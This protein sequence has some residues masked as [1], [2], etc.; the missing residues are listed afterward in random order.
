MAG[1]NGNL[2]STLEIMDVR[3]CL[4][5]DSLD[6]GTLCTSEKVNP[7]SRYR[8]GYWYRGSDGVLAFQRPRGK[9]Y[10][11]PRTPVD[12][13]TGLTKEYYCLHHFFGYN[14]SARP[15]GT[16]G[17]NS[18]AWYEPSGYAYVSGYKF[19]LGEVNWNN[20]DSYNWWSFN[21]GDL[22]ST[23][24]ALVL[25]YYDTSSAKWVQGSGYVVD[26]PQT[27]HGVI[28][29]AV[30]SSS[31]TTVDPGDLKLKAFGLKAGD[32]VKMRIVPYF[33]GDGEDAVTRFPDS[34]I[35][36][37]IMKRQSKAILQ[38]SVEEDSSLAGKFNDAATSLNKNGLLWANPMM[39]ITNS[40][41]ATR[42]EYNYGVYIDVTSGVTYVSGYISFAAMGSD[43]NIYYMGTSNI[44]S[45]TA[46]WEIYN[47]DNQRLN[48]V[49]DTAI[50]ITPTKGVTAYDGTTVFGIVDIGI[51]SYYTVAGA[52]SGG[53][54]N[55]VLDGYKY[56]LKLRNFGTPIITLIDN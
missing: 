54:S 20:D 32:E 49:S 48:L 44:K 30:Y 33:S 6:L 38:V 7:W 1:W 41:T 53:T 29:K 3:N 14:H 43:G 56:Y 4:D 37:F 26:N 23:Y 18:I 10:T 17:G 19:E 46:H 2:P 22:S 13:K 39:S 12:P 28:Y 9:D 31:L 24:V 11:D 40:N 34:C 55:A 52:T 45:I 8:P 21:R 51:P 25:E 42:P 50:T 27:T 47:A 35:F 15:A 5:V 16:N 36:N